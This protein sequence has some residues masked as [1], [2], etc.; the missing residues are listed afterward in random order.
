MDSSK[1][2]LAVADI[3]DASFVLHTMFNDRQV[4]LRDKFD[5]IICGK[6]P[7]WGLI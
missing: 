4:Y 5:S 1:F 6:H 2:M 7:A 3:A